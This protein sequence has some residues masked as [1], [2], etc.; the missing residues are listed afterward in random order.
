MGI[1]VFPFNEAKAAQCAAAFLKLSRTGRIDHVKLVRLM[2]LVDRQALLDWGYP[3]TTDQFVFTTSGPIL[4]RVNTLITEGSLTPPTWSEYISQLKGSPPDLE[5]ELRLPDAPT[6]ELSMAEEQLIAQVFSAHSSKTKWQLIEFTKGLPEWV[7][8]Q[9][10]AIPCSYSDL[11][12]ANGKTAPEI[13]AIM[14]DLESHALAVSVFEPWCS[15]ASRL[16]A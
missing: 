4:T 9:G 3:V 13:A 7:D 2:Y 1:V 15:G 14:E 11:L 5:V 6:G 16:D 10:S 8:P 12:K